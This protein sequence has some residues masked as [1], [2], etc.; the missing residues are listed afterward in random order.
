MFHVFFC[1]NASCHSSFPAFVIIL[2]WFTCVS[3]ACP[4][5][6]ICVSFIVCQFIVVPCAFV[7]ALSPW[8]SILVCFGIFVSGLC[9]LIG[10]DFRLIPHGFVCFYIDCF[11]GFDPASLSV[12]I[13]FCI[14]IWVFHLLVS[15]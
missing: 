9:L 6:C 8:V 1:S 13:V 2:T 12:S 4:P 5:L 14:S 3:S 11:T 10:F 15:T 7:P